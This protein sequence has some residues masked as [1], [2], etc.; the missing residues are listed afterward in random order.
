MNK[1]L[2][3]ILM[4]IPLLCYILIFLVLLKNPLTEYSFMP[5]SLLDIF[6]SFVMTLYIVI[7]DIVAF[8]YNFKLLTPFKIILMMIIS[9][10]NPVIHSGLLY[11]LWGIKIGNLLEPDDGTIMITT[12]YM[13]IPSIALVVLFA[14]LITIHSMY[15]ET[16]K[17]KDKF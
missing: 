8:V 12:M 9:I 7:I 6:V 4:S 15:F 11:L 14:I 1:K 17:S 16:Q 5:L 2:Y 3:L 13:W 10:L